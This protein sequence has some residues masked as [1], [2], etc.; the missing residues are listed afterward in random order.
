MALETFFPRATQKGGGGGVSG[1]EQGTINALDYE[2][3]FCISN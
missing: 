2:K 1:G 3:V